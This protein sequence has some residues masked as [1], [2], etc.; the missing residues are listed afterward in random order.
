MKSKAEP[1]ISIK[2]PKCGTINQTMPG[3]TLV[4]CKGCT[5]LVV[6]DLPAKKQSA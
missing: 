4:M 2:C 5:A 6:I 1:L 3:S